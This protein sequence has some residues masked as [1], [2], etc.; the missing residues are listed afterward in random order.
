MKKLTAILLLTAAPAVG[1]GHARTPDQYHDDTMA[2]VAKKNDEIKACYDQALKADA[3][4]HGEVVLSFVVLAGTGKV[5]RVE[6]VKQETTAPDALG[7]CV[8]GATGDMVL[9]P[10][11]A[12]TGHAKFKWNFTVRGG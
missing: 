9:Q 4:A 6:L 12:N 7:R 1:C 2:L 10:P 3:K 5:V 8:L 11:D